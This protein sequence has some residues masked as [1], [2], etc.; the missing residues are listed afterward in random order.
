MADLESLKSRYEALK[1]QNLALDMTRG[2]PSQAQLDL[3]LPLLSILKETDYTTAAGVDCRNYSSPD[4]LA[5][6]GELK[7]LFAECYDLKEE[8]IILGGNSSLKLM[9]DVIAAAML[10]PLPDA[11]VSWSKASSVKF[12]CPSPGYDRHFTICEALGIQMIP[13]KLTGDGP[14]MDEVEKL[15]LNDSS[16]KGIWCV[17]KYSNPTGEVYSDKVIQRL[18]SMATAAKD[19]RIF[20]DNAYAVH[21]LH[22]EPAEILDIFSACDQVGHAN[23]VF[24]FASTSKITFAGGGVA[25]VAAGD[26]NVAW[27]KQ[28][29][30]YQ[31][32][33]YDKLNQLRHLNFLETKAGLLNHMRQH[34]R[35][36]KPK[37]DAVLRVL[38][39]ELG[40]DGQFATWTEPDGGYFIS[41]DTKHG[42]AKQVVQMANEA[43]VKLTKAGA[44]YPYGEDPLDANIRI[45]PSMPT[46]AEIVQ[47]SEVLA[48][49]IQIAT[50]QADAHC[51]V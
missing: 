42:L 3:S 18:A 19:F 32:I 39:K 20:W 8:N 38:D 2:K 31:T 29:L 47:A 28:K 36:L 40:N 37:F 27:F 34:A 48:L 41:L 49:C 9:Y 11:D 51:V 22:D 23:R 10:Y 4:L 12:L 46:V 6:L 33:G 35:I 21:Y 50:L 16:I 13:V 7:A 26:E 30:S 44:T 5:G 24:S 14:D 45:A 1:S 17:P 15:V 25:L 43:G